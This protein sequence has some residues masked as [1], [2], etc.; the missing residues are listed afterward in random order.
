LGIQPNLPV[1]KDKRAEGIAE[2]ILAVRNN[3]QKSLSSEELFDWHTMLMKGNTSVKVGQWRN[4]EV[5]M[6]IVSGAMGREVVHY[7]VP[8]SNRVPSEMDSFIKWFNNSQDT[9]KKPI[10]R[11]AVAHLHF[12]SIHPFEDGNG[13]IG[14]ATAEKALS[15]SIGRPVL[16]SLSKSIEGNKKAYYD[17][18]QKAQRSN[19]ISDWIKYF[20]RTVLDA[21]IDAEQEIEF[22]L[23]KTRFFDQHK[24]DI[25]DRQQK[26][27]RRMLE[28]GYQG[29]EGGMN[30]RKYVSLTGT[31]KATATR[32]LQDLVE[33]KIFIPIGG[34]RSTRYEIM[35]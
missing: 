24:N 32:D 25:N 15:Q 30:A 27:V 1:T 7:E 18:L 12:E 28:E 17:A 20:V 22:T 16:F 5:P 2:L 11:A 31:S 13:R 34:G 26:V 14:R 33:K 23:K 10:L 21:Q 35:L 6:Q 4:H 3:F 9:F 29:F 8:P 19:E